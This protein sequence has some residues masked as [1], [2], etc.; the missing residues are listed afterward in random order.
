MYRPVS[1]LISVSK[2]IELIVN[3]K[4]LNYFESNNL[5]P[6][7]QHGFRQKRSTFSAVAAMHE[8]WVE[9]REKRKHQALAFLDLSAAFDTLSKDVFCKKLEVYG[10]DNNSVNWFRSYLS[11]R[12]QYVM[13]G[14]EISSPI[15][16]DL[17][18][19]Q[20]AIMSPTIFLILVA[21]IEQWAEELTCCN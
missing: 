2:V 6:N 11:E 15:T 7:S 13:I 5:F 8:E 3:K 18:S 4:V 10:F 16:L 17:G 21:D 19:P 20:G 1:N 12:I 14:S 9:N